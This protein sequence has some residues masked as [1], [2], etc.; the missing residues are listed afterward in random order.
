MEV[1]G[2]LRTGIAGAVLAALFCFTPVLVVALAAV[3]LGA[4]VGW[5]DY[6]L[7]PAL[8]VSIGII[9]YAVL[10]KNRRG[11]EQTDGA[12]PQGR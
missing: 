11:S 2:L 10:R 6:V 8:V 9:V 7:L 5:L 3:G 4:A 12:Q 1:K